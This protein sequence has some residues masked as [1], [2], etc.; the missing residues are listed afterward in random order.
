M[1]QYSF[2]LSLSDVF[3]L[4]QCLQ[5]PSV[6]SQKA[7]FSSFIWLNN[8]PVCV[9]VHIPHFLYFSTDGHLSCFHVLAIVNNATVNMGVQISL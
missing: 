4:V 1:R 3:H 8:I 5:G 9:C 6:L 2:C 7:G